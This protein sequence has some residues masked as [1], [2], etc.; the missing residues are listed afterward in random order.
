MVEEEDDRVVFV[1]SSVITCGGKGH[2]SRDCPSE[3]RSDRL[4]HS[5][6][7]SASEKSEQAPKVS[8]PQ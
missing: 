3:K 6:R 1:M 4:Q 8:P 2:I 7:K 5:Q